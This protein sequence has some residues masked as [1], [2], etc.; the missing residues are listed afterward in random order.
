MQRNQ[1]MAAKDISATIN[2]MQEEVIRR[3][4]TEFIPPNSMIEEWDVSGLENT[5]AG[6][7]GQ[8]LPV[9]DWLNSNANLDDNSLTYKILE[10]IRKAHLEKE[11]LISSANMR[12]FEKS[13]MLNT[14]DNLWKEHLSTMDYLR[15]SIHLRGYA[16]KDP[17]QEYKREAFYLFSELL[18]TIKRD[19][20][21]IL[22][23]V[24]IKANSDVDAADESMRNEPTKLEYQHA[25]AGS[26]LSGSD[27]N[28]KDATDAENSRPFMRSE[29]K[30]GRNDLC[31]CG[32]NKKY[33]QCHGKV[34]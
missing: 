6:E 8:K 21:A 3:V 7:F 18:E 14:L 25:D 29:P 12:L 5:L 30:V 13:V 11:N 28:N 34:S 10:H 16:Q 20:I 32:S 33:K 26:V 15:Q 17:K 1:L 23:K 22:S 9:S 19:V 31:P 2:D 4:V 27:N 24:E